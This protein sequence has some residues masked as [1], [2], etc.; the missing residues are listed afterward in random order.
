MDAQ[1]VILFG[2]SLLI[3][4]LAVQLGA[5][6]GLV[7][8]R[9]VTAAALSDC[10]PAVV[11]FDLATVRAE[12]VL[13]WLTDCAHLSLVGIDLQRSRVMVFTAGAVPVASVEQLGELVGRLVP[14]AAP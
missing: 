3:A 6:P 12:L 8:Q 10:C 14:G 5:I 11:V 2:N 1:Q 13:G 4:G 7:V 9:V